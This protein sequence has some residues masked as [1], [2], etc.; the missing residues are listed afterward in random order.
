MS[1]IDDL[2]KKWRTGDEPSGSFQFSQEISIDYF[3]S[4]IVAKCATDLESRKAAIEREYRLDELIA[5]R[6]KLCPMC[7]Q[8]PLAPDFRPP[9]ELH[10]QRYHTEVRAATAWRNRKC[11][12]PEWLGQRIAELEASER[13]NMADEVKRLALCEEYATGYP[14]FAPDD[15]A[16]LQAVVNAA[17]VDHPEFA[18]NC[19]LC[20]ALRA[21]KKRL[22]EKEARMK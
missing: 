3:R 11:L 15:A 14:I 7:A 18:S 1:E 9:F 8:L 21:L 16:L 19:K 17:H 10:D 20:L 6:N 4:S 12:A 13:Q 5:L 22:R 2:I